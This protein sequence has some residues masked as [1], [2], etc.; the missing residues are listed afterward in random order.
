MSPSK[1]LFYCCLSF[2]GGVGIVS[3]VAVPQSFLWAFLILGIALIFTS[4]PLRKRRKILLLAGFL[5]LFFLLGVARFLAAQSSVQNNP[6]RQLNDKPEKILLMGQVVSQPDVRAGIQRLKVHIGGADSVVLVTA[7][8]RHEYR[9][10]DT[11]KMVGKLKTPMV[12]E[13]F[14]YKDYL[15]K[16]RIYS[17]MDFPEI[18]VVA[19]ERA[20][21][22]LPWAYEK[23]IW[24]KKLLQDSIKK[25]F[26]PNDGALVQGVLMGNDTAM[27][28][29]VRKK[30]NDAGLSHV[31]A[32][33]GGNIVM[34]SAIA[35][36]LLLAAG[37]WR[38]QALY[39]A[40]GLVWLYVAIAGFP[41]SGVRA[42]IMASLMLAAQK[43]GRPNTA[44][45]T[46]VFAAVIMIFSN[47]FLLRYDVGFQLSFLATLGIICAKPL[48]DALF[49]FRILEPEG[50]LY[51]EF[52]GRGL[53]GLFFWREIFKKWTRAGAEILT[54][55]L[56][57]QLFVIPLIAYHFGTVSLMAPLSNLLALPII[58]ALMG[59]GFLSAAF[60]IF[61]P[62][63]AW[64]FYLPAKAFSWYFFFIAG[65][66]SH[67]LMSMEFTVPWFWLIAYYLIL[68]F[69]VF[70]WNK[71]KKEEI[72]SY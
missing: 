56:A 67:P 26:S 21:N 47:P 12:S 36:P 31:T 48:F 11:I 24:F 64:V 66:F 62:F 20:R 25:N 13:D 23:I 14:N 7:N 41:S 27:D 58:P 38:G 35:L 57:A 40:F 65:I 50:Q 51:Y 59:A 19:G 60:G 16:D 22:P 33:S 52:S 70:F 2:V 44:V 72:F 34:M 5:I 55:T 4:F 68:I 49:R 32:V 39:W 28:K 18:E 1:A 46:V 71:K 53:Y 45:R 54:V 43:L 6:L 10:L 30:V 69:I 63:L 15:M 8:L 9:Y 37:L 3:F 61:S 42:A 17:V 29:E